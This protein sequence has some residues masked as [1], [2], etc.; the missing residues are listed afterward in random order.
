MLSDLTIF[1][2]LSISFSIAFFIIPKI[3]KVARIKHLF[4]I[5]NHRSASKQVVPRLGGMAILFGFVLGLIFSSGNMRIYSLKYILAAIFIMFLVG[6]KDDLIGL[7]AKKKLYVQIAVAIMLVYLGK[8]RITNLHGIFGLNEVNFIS[9]TIISIVII[10]GLINAI[11]LTD[12]IDGLAGGISLLVSVVYG[13]L[14]MQSGDYTYAL[15]SFSVAGSLIAFLIYNVFGK[16][17]KIFMGDSGSLVV[18]T[19][20][21]IFTIHFNE[22]TSPS[23]SGMDLP[24]I[25]LALLIYPVVDTLRVFA[26]RM[27]QKKSPFA[28]DMNHIHHNLLRL[29]K[30]HF[31][32]T[33]IIL[34]V[35]GLIVL[36]A[37]GFI[38]MIGNAWLFFVMLILGFMLA[39]IPAKLNRMK[40][41]DIN[42]L[43]ENKSIF[44]LF[45]FNRKLKDS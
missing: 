25:S 28:P 12:G 23:P 43:E 35:N 9:G 26:I 3:V 29:T 41:E 17:N 20:L 21:A 38:T 11:N 1:F 37:F 19:L 8:F 10:V 36:L 45:L 4:D 7:A 40:D 13:Y 15:V 24:S 44:A 31:T 16:S 18:G 5:P 34:G 42:A 6:L 32:T 39:Y 30:N 2:S 14:F 22:F 27:K 33:L